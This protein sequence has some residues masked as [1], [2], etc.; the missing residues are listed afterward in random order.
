M[1]SLIKIVLIIFILVILFKN[2]EKFSQAP[3]CQVDFNSDCED[4]SEAQQ[5]YGCIHFFGLKRQGDHQECKS[6]GYDYCKC[7]DG[8]GNCVCAKESPTP[9]PTPAVFTPTPAAPTPTKDKKEAK[10]PTDVDKILIKNFGYKWVDGIA[11]APGT[12]PN[13]VET[14]TNK[15]S[16]DREI[17]PPLSE[18]DFQEEPPEWLESS[19]GSSDLDFQPPNWLESS[20][21]SSDLD[22]QEEALKWLESSTGPSDLGYEKV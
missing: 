14:P 3:I 19:K 10:E 18:L 8:I 20:T 21:G 7:P 1:K 2:K 17:P 5:K 16:P 13:D 12:A 15:Y 9:T 6:E 4:G 22:F 11:Y